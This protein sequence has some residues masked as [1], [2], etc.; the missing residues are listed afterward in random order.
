MSGK[1]LIPR[2]TV[3]QIVACRN[4]ALELYGEAFTAIEQAD[5]AIKAA[6]KMAA[7][8]SGDVSVYVNGRENGCG[9]V[10]DFEKAVKLPSRELYEGVAR[11]LT[12]LRVWTW[13]IHRTDLERLMDKQAKDKLREQ[14]R[15][16]PAKKDREGQ[17]ITGEEVEAGM[18]V[19]SVDNIYATIQQFALDA[20]SIFKRGVANAFSQLDRRFRSHDGFKVGSRIIMTY[21]FSSITGSLQYGGTRD[22]LL[23]IE[24]AF[25]VLDKQ[26]VGASYGGAVG[27]LYEDRQK[28][29]FAPHQSYTETKYFR[30]RGFCNGNAHLWMTRPDLVEKVNKL[31]ADWYGEVIADGQTNDDPFR[32]R[33]TTLARRFGFFPTPDT[34]AEHLISKVALWREPTQPPLTILEPSAGTGA[35]ARRCATAGHV[36]NKW[37]EERGEERSYPYNHRVD[38]VEVQP[39][40]ARALRAEK[41]YRR[42]WCG[43]FLQMQP[44]PKRLYDRIV[45][46]PPFDLERDV[47]HVTHALKFLAPEGQLVAIMS[48][49]TEFRETKKAQAL[50]ALVKA[51]HGRWD[52]LPACSFASVGTNVNTILLQLWNN[53]RSVHW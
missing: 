23:D 8:A 26:H 32:K 14:M 18:P 38:C 12:D 5:T 13:V 52:D 33:K 19:V 17:L 34:T 27:Q 2:A 6:H 29:P 1:E 22:T 40:L 25:A 15:Y 35:L 41:L 31:L 16:I 45:M 24:R 42:V 10:D 48:A 44:D 9:E 50:R 30:I 36:A 21:A 7:L 53:G 20:D 4:R 46:N 39:K 11:R 3:E 47:D 51:K 43:D 28:G 49:G 37:R